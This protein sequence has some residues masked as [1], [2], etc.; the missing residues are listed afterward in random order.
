LWYETVTGFGE[1]IKNIISE[2]YPEGI[3]FAAGDLASGDIDNDGDIDVLGP[4]SP[5]EWGGTNRPLTLS[6]TGTKI[7]VG[8]LIK[9]PFF[10]VL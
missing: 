10:R 9:S 6:F 7:L 5:G 1:S 3:K 2:T 4:V 8:K